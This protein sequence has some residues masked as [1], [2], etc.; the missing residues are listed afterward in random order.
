MERVYIRSGSGEDSAGRERTAAAGGIIR[1]RRAL[2]EKSQRGF[3]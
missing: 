3:S 1:P 2:V